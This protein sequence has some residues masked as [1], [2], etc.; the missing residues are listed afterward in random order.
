MSDHSDKEVH[1][2]QSM[3]ISNGNRNKLIASSNLTAGVLGKGGEKG[4]SQNLGGQNPDI[5][6]ASLLLSHNSLLSLL[7]Q[8]YNGN[9]SS[10]NTLNYI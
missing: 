2:W 7:C 1:L 9:K 6:P 4:S 8:R 10:E 3:K 5:V